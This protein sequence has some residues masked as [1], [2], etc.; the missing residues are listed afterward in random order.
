MINTTSAS[1]CT[2]TEGM[3]EQDLAGTKW[4]LH[5]REKAPFI[6]HIA[7][8]RPGAKRERE[9]EKERER[10]RERECVGV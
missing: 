9:R 7:S 8:P 10:E 6:D 3:I 5:A 2:P 1:L 4:G